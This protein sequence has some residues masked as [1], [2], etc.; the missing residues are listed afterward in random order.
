MAAMIKEYL[1]DTNASK[2]I[3]NEVLGYFRQALRM[4]STIDDKQILYRLPFHLRTAI[5]VSD[6]KE[7][8][9]AIP[10]FAHIKSG[11]LKL[12]LLNLLTFCSAEKG[13]RL[14]KEG[15]VASEVILMTSGRATICRIL[16]IDEMNDSSKQSSRAKKNKAQGPVT[17]ST[18]VMGKW[19]ASWLLT[20]LTFRRTRLL[21]ILTRRVVA[22]VRSN[23]GPVCCDTKSHSFR[24]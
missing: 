7:L 1:R 16:D 9:D 18:I 14:V 5:L 3:T 8:F 22:S 10:L 20:P 4:H 19:E 23:N 15:S 11:S 12:F 17:V 6:A 2:H 13:H 21:H 24:S